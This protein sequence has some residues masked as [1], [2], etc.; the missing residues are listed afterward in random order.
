MASGSCTPLCPCPPKNG[1]TQALKRLSNLTNEYT[2]SKSYVKRGSNISSLLATAT[3][4]A[5]QTP[6]A[7]PLPRG[8]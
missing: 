6:R 7:L 8:L 2:D 3:L 5:T 4:T 1:H